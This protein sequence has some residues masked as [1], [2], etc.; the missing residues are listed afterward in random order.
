MYC[1]IAT[2][3]RCEVYYPISFYSG[4]PSLQLQLP[5]VGSADLFINPF[6][7][8]RECFLIR[9]PQNQTPSG[10]F[11]LT[12]REIAFI[13]AN[14][15]SGLLSARPTSLLP[16]RPGTSS[17]TPFIPTNILCWR[18]PSTPAARARATSLY[19]HCA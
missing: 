9:L 8:S 10:W 1:S 13:Q 12:P 18:P 11:T 2:T 4:I 5:K 3:Y 16:A 15:F 14:L 17:P 19:L 7:R 6:K